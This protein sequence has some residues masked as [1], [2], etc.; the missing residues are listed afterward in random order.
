MPLRYYVQ[1]QVPQLMQ[2]GTQDRA[3]AIEGFGRNIGDGLRTLTERMEKKKEE[4]KRI[5]DNA[6]AAETL[7][8]A[9][10]ELQQQIGVSPEAFKALSAREKAATMQGAV[11]HITLQKAAAEN[12]R[13][14]AEQVSAQALQRAVG[15]ASRGRMSD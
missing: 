5:L 3:R 15:Q 4:E 10:P 2:Q 7:F 6:K 13:A 8:T 14:Q 12:R 1:D 11:T 9:N